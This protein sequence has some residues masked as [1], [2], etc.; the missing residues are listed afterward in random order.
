MSHAQQPVK[1]GELALPRSGERE[2]ALVREDADDEEVDDWGATASGRVGFGDPGR[3]AAARRAEMQDRLRAAQR[4]DEGAS[5]DDDETKLKP[6]A[7]DDEE[8]VVS[9]WEEEQIRKAAPKAARATAA[10]RSPER[11]A[12]VPRLPSSAPHA[13]VVRGSAPGRAAL[14]TPSSNLPR[15]G[16]YRVR[17]LRM[18][19]IAR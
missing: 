16:A 4:E 12:N 10:P 9:R 13:V 5:D 3:R 17:N 14:S 7:G 2:S 19:A 18:F 15:H 1:S 11:A 6:V 8:D